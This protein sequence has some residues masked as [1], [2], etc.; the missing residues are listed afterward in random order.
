MQNATRKLALPSET[1]YVTGY[2]D[3]EAR[4]VRATGL[5]CPSRRVRRPGL[6]LHPRQ[7]ADARRGGPPRLRL[8][9]PRHA[10]LPPQ[11]RAPAAAQG[12]GGAAD[13]PGLPP[14]LRAAAD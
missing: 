8:L 7:L 14:P 9:V 13:L 11:H 5:R 12:A 6:G 10:R 2:G 3:E 4:A 1:A